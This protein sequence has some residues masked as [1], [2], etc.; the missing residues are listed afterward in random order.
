MAKVDFTPTAS[1]T[2]GAPT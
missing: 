1:A 2:G